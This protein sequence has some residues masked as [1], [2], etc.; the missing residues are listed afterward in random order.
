MGC[1]S[2]T[3]APERSPERAATSE[4][5]R[6]KTAA[7]LMLLSAIDRSRPRNRYHAE[8]PSTNTADSTNDE[9]TVCE[10]LFIAT[11]DSNTSKKEVIS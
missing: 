5:T 1:T 4:N 8:T 2:A 11:G 3:T 9:V 10:N 6:P 7:T